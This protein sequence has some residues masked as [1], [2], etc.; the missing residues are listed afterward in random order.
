MAENLSEKIIA[1]KFLNL[2]KD[3]DI[4]FQEAQRLPNKMNPKGPH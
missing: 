2:G 4:H 1:E 3:V